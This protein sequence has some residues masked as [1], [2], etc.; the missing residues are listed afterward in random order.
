MNGIKIPTCLVVLLLHAIHFVGIGVVLAPMIF[1][2][3]EMKFINKVAFSSKKKSPFFYIRKEEALHV[4]HIP[5]RHKIM[6]YVLPQL[7]S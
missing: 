2:A 4:C 6:H 5:K 1:V 7:S 3:P